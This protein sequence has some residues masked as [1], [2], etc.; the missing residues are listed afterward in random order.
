M[1]VLEIDGS[2]GEGGGQI[3]RTAVSLA[4]VTGRAV[5]VDRIRAGRPHPGMAAQHLTAVRAVAAVCDARLDGDE[6][7]SQSLLFEPRTPPR[8]GDYFSDVAEA[9]L[10]GSAGS[11][12]LVLQALLPPLALA[13]G[14]SRLRIQGGTHMAWSP[15]FDYLRDVWAPAMGRLGI[16]VSITLDAWGWFPLGRGAVAAE[17]AGGA[18]IGAMALDDPGALLR[19]TGR[20]V[21]ANLPAHIP[22]RMAMRAESLLREAGVAAQVRPER[23][24][25]ASAGAGIFLTAEYENCAAGFSVLGRIGMPSEAVAEEAVAALLDH[26]ASGAAFDS[27]LA[28][29]VLV[30]LALAGAPSRFTTERASRHLDTNA[31]VIEQFGLARFAVA[32]A[33]RRTEVTVTPEVRSLASNRAG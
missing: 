12:S 7:N 18:P 24:R 33:G 3:L 2:H 26:R 8:A 1:T 5:H 14:T 28:D 31:W 17:I 13:A 4:A 22:Q 16:R 23:V 15:P 21:A 30:P 20:A 11:V 25:A 6:L 10:G 19:V 27:H 9:R 32:A 29:Q